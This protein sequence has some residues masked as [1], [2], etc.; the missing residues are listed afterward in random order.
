[1]EQLAI[2]HIIPFVEAHRYTAYAILFSAMVVEGETFLVVAGALAAIKALD[3]GDIFFFALVG[4]LV[5]DALWYYLGKILAQ[6]NVFPKILSRAESTV[7]FFLPRFREKPFASIFFSKFIYG[8]NHAAL[9]ISGVMKVSFRIFMEAEFFA[10]VA[11]VALFLCAGYFF[12]Q[13][14]TYFTQK[15]L[16][17]ALILLGFMVA[18]VLLQK[19]LARSYERKHRK[20]QNKDSDPQW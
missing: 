19:F 3:V 17:G 15:A 20:K 4:V 8:V 5:G 1:M 14:A 12:G 2:E 6:K 16:Y 10:S 11:W 18:F 13:A 9:I 7:L